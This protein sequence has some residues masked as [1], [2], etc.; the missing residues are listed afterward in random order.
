MSQPTSRKV[1]K[2]AMLLK[3]IVAIAVLAGL[4]VA[5]AAMFRGGSSDEGGPGEMFAVAR[6]SF[7]ISIT[8]NGELQAARQI[9]LRS[10]LEK[11]AS[12][13]ELVPEGTR[14]QKGDLLVRLNAEE[15]ET[16]LQEE[17]AKV[18][19]ARSDLIAAENDY[20]IQLKENES[21]LRQANLKLDLARIDHQKWLEGDDVKRRQEIALKI[22]RAQREKV[23]LGEKVER[24]R[25]LHERG[26]LAT[27]TLKIDETN[28]VEA[29]A[30]LETATL[31]QQVYEEYERPKQIKTLTSAIEEAEGEID[32]VVSKN[33]SQLA[34]RE[35]NRNNRREQLRIREER[36]VKLEEQLAAAEI[37]APNDG[38]VVYGTTLESSRWGGGGDEGLKIGNDVRPNELLIALPDTSDM[39]AEVRVHESLAGRI[40]PG[41]KATV[42]IDAVQGRVFDGEVLS[43]GV[44]AIS[45]GWRDPNLREYTVRIRLTADDAKSL[46]KPAMRCEANIV[47][48]Q[49]DDVL[50][51]PIQAVFNEGR[52]R[53]VYTPDGDR[54]VQTP[55]RPGRRSEVFIEVLAGLD[56]GDRVLL[57][58]PDVREVTPGGLSDERVAALGGGGPGGGPGGGEGRG[59]PGARPAGGDGAEGRPAADGGEKPATVGQKAGEAEGQP[60]PAEAAPATASAND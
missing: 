57:R 22:E 21:A 37:V 14:V 58:K 19:S 34:S 46:L 23:R 16:Q 24:S 11:S 33:A 32:R 8:A 4:T 49:V 39:V 7:D 55:I 53:Y 25:L 6:T 40:K 17:R 52:I 31:E 43:V 47:L 28:Y 54:Y 42:K 30:N 3:A 51:V 13:V 12:I 10:K 2:G 26:F 44:L 5:A 59:M 9:E 45:G 56:P 41:Q 35:A 20:D 18:E 1:R 29:V 27:D 60:K 38:L 48:G 36:Q 15:I 50:A